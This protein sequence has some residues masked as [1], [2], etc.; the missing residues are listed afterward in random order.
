[1]DAA[2][3]EPCALVEAVLGAVRRGEDAERVEDVALGRCVAGGQ[4]E[5]NR[6]GDPERA[7][8]VEVALHADVEARACAAV[9]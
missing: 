9:P 4:L 8:T 7:E 6:L 2:A 3:A 1:M 5:Q